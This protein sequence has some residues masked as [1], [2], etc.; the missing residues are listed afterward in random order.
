LRRD[1]VQWVIEAGVALV[2]IDALNI[3]DVNDIARPAHIGLLGAGI[4]IIEHMT[5]L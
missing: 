3:D 1:G 2:G 5:N 4:P